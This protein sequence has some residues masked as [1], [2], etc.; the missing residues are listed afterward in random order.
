MSGTRTALF[1]LTFSLAFVFTLPAQESAL[2]F[3][4][5]DPEV[6]FGKPS[7]PG[8]GIPS[9]SYLRTD[10]TL[11]ITGGSV[12]AAG[13]GVTLFIQK[14]DRLAGGFPSALP[15]FTAL[16]HG[17]EFVSIYSAKDFLP[18]PASETEVAKGARVGKIGNPGEDFDPDYRFRVFDGSSRLWVNP[19]FFIQDFQ[20]RAA[21]KIEEITLLGEGRSYTAENRKNFTQTIRQGDYALAV[22]VIDP[23][24]A[25]G[26]VS[27]MYGFKALLDGKVFVDR[28]FDSA[29]ITDKGLAFLGLGAPSSSIVDNGGRIILDGQFI[30]NGLHSLEFSAYDYAGNTSN[31]TWK[32]QV[33]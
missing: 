7:S 25:R 11:S 15:N 26:S 4:G 13:Q 31:F 18:E 20:D 12:I 1:A 30:P 27:G 8:S 24:Y 9:L 22:R 5:I 32:F 6:N 29:R 33:E 28:K 10:A 14:E 21:P 3:T 19:V 2:G 17:N 23:P 16:A